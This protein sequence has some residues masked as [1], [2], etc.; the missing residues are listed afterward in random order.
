MCIRD[1]GETVPGKEFSLFPGGKGANQAAA[2]AKLGGNVAIAGRI[3]DDVF[4]KV[5][6]DS[7]SS[8]KVG[9][10]HIVTTPGDVYKR[11]TVSA[12]MA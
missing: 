4:S 12:R 8:A 11:Q 6:L 1:R 5:L 3:G 9:Q 7:L 10:E 2:A